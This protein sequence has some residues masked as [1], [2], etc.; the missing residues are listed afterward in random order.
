MT[1]WRD[2]ASLEAQDDLDRLL[3]E[4]LPFARDMLEKSGEFFPY[5]IA[6]TTSGEVNLVA[7]DPGEGDQ[8][9]SVAVLQTLVAGLRDQ[10]DTNRAA[11]LISDVRLPDSDAIRVELEHSE[12]QAIVAL[13]PYRVKRLRRGIEYGEIRAGQGERQI[14]SSTIDT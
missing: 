12:G 2:S 7:G 3:D 6:L 10:A 14:W 5:A 9:S 13:L 4:S 11:A 1:S 8:P